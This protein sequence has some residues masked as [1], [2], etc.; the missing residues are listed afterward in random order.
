MHLLIVSDAWLP[1]VNGVVRTLQ[2][3]INQLEI[4]GHQVSMLTPDQFYTLPCPTYPEIRLA[5][6]RARTIGA[7]IKALNPD[8]IHIATEG[9]L[10]L[11][12]RR[13]CVALGLSFT[14]AFHTRF[15][16]YVQVRMGIPARWTWPFF[17]WF[18][19]KASAIMVATPSLAQELHTQGLNQTRLWGRGVDT[20]HF[21]PEL[22]LPTDWE[23]LPRPLQLYVGRVTSEKNIDAFLSCEHPGQK[24]VVGEGPELERYRQSYPAVLFT[25]VLTGEALARAFSAADV[26]VFPSRTDTFGIVLLEALA[27]GTPIAAYPVCGPLDIVGADGC[28]SSVRSV[29]PIGHLAHN[30]DDAIAQALLC[31]RADARAFAEQFSWLACT[32][33]FLSNLQPMD[34]QRPVLKVA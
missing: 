26:F 9:T 3:T 21:R 17:R 31:K 8:A 1:Q 10:G 4:L 7:K 29:R 12:A 5:M 6:V 30:L 15:P 18:H 25:G 22:P 33:Q 27:S 20:Q 34:L 28:G 2:T 16:D 11:A 13:A 19:Q 24:I 23:A 32:K 14:T